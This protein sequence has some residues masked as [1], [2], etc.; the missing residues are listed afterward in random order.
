M[1]V[2]TNFFKKYI[3][4]KFVNKNIKIWDQTLFINLKKI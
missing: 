3:L 2:A 1:K 4:Y